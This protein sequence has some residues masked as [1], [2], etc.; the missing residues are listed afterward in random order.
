MTKGSKDRAKA[1]RHGSQ[2]VL[3]TKSDEERWSIR[4]QKGMKRSRLYCHQTRRQIAVS[5]AIE[6]ANWLNKLYGSGVS[7]AVVFCVIRMTCKMN[8]LMKTVLVGS[9]C[10]SML[11][12]TP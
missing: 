5:G 6:I 2:N 3:A 8:W 10:C 1:R 12:N 7:G 4:S 11:V 9:N